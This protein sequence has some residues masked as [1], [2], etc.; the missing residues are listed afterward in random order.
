[1]ICSPAFPSDVGV[2][3]HALILPY[4]RAE[5]KIHVLILSFRGIYNK[6]M[7]TY[8]SKDQNSRNSLIG[9]LNS[10]GHLVIAVQANPSTH[11]LFMADATTGSNNGPSNA[12]PD[13]NF[14]STLLGTSYV[15]NATPVAI[16]CDS[17]GNLLVDSTT[18]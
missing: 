12:L 4:F 6:S 5:S 7:A 8:A 14:V 13:V 3:F 15:D 16:Y 18:Q 10:S 17:S 2:C 1:M 11:Q 9:V